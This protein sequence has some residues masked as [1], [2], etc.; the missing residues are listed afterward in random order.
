MARKKAQISTV[1]LSSAKNLS[2]RQRFFLSGA[3]SVFQLAGFPFRLLS[4]GNPSTDKR[5]LQ[6]DWSAIGKDLR[7]AY[8]TEIRKVDNKIAIKNV[9]R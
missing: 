2:P 7:K 8:N 3:A 9:P 5:A 4:S 6:S 1:T